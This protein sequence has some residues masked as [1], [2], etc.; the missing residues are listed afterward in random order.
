MQPVGFLLILEC[1]V[2]Y[3]EGHQK[4]AVTSPVPRR[5]R[6]RDIGP[7]SRCIIT[8]LRI[9]RGIGHG[10]RQGSWRSATWLC[11]LA[12]GTLITGRGVATFYWK[13]LTYSYG[14]RVHNGGWT[15]LL[16]FFCVP[17][18][19]K[20]RNCWTCANVKLLFLIFVLLL[21][22][23]DWVLEID[24]TMHFILLLEDF[25]GHIDN[26]GTA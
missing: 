23:L 22:S 26:D 18:I 4:P 16:Y 14:T 6:S 24:L 15:V 3:L 12:Y 5:P 2:T 20:E 1:S 19:W 10:P 9:G 13:R 8:T 17:T 25:Y 11:K 7:S 21:K